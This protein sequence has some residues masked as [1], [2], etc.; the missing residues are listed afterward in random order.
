MPLAEEQGEEV[1]CDFSM[2]KE[3]EKREVQQ[4]LLGAIHQL[5]E[6]DSRIFLYK[7]FLWMKNKEIASAL[8]LSEKKVENVLF[9][10][11]DKLRKLLEER[12][13]TGYE[14]G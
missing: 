4:F 7:F 3:T 14:M 11:K 13:I 2:E 6:P 5:G 10:G 9:R 8:H 1:A 12:G